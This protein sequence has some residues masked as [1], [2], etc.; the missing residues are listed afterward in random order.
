MSFTNISG[1]TI[2]AN[3]ESIDEELENILNELKNY[4]DEDVF[5]RLVKDRIIFD[6]ELISGDYNRRE[7]EKLSIEKI[8]EDGNKTTYKVSYGEI[9]YSDSDKKTL[10]KS[11][12]FTLEN[13]GELKIKDIE[14]IK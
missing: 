5:N 10:N 11:R 8:E 4:F 9:L 13:N 14:N 3:E 6:G 12:S 7:I 2:V 1:E